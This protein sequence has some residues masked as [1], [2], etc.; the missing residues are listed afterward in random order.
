MGLPVLQNIGERAH[1]S[2]KTGFVFDLFLTR[3]EQTSRRPAISKLSK[4]GRMSRMVMLALALLLSTAW[5]QAQNQYPPS[6][7]SQN[8][9]SSGQTSIEGCLQG[10]NGVSH[11]PT[12]PERR[13]NFRAI[14]RSSA[15]TSGTTFRSLV[16]PPVRAPRVLAATRLGVFPS[17]TH[18]LWT[19]R[20]IYP[21]AAKP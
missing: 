9:H 11:S 4:G 12:A 14:H 21:R 3:S 15:N 18:F 19:K 8:K 16:L 5:L 10:S 7:S 17:N 20:N 13:T 1:G 2:Q 6:G